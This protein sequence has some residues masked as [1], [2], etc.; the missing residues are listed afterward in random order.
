MGMLDERKIV[1]HF[2]NETLVSVDRND[3]DVTHQTRI[4]FKE[5]LYVQIN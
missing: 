1:I 3:F 4:N 5:K 2:L